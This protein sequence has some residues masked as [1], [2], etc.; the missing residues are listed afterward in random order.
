MSNVTFKP[1]N[2]MVLLRMVDVGISKGGVHIPQIS[3]HGKEYHVVAIGPK[4][5]GLAIGDKVMAAGRVNVDFAFLPGFKDLFIIKQDNV[6]MVYT[7]EPEHY[8]R[9]P[10]GGELT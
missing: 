6:Q 1:R 8:E 7:E 5:E 9:L 4:V 2:D 3:D 10:E